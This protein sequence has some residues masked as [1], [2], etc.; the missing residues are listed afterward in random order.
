[1]TFALSQRSRANMAGVHPDLVRVVELGITL[2]PHDF[3]VGE[4]VRAVA[5]EMELFKAGFSHTLDSKHLVQSDG[6]GHAVDLI[7]VGDLNADGTVDAHDKSLTWNKLIYADIAGAMKLAALK[8]RV[9]IR[10]G[11]DFGPRF[12]DGPHFEL[13]GHAMLDDDPTPKV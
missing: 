5:R 1:M 6:F 2:S 12:F 8:L 7:A 13:A 4:G 3:A 9:S 10:W 11:G